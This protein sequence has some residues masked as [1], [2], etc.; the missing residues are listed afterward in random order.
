MSESLRRIASPF[1]VG[2]PGG[3]RVRTRLAV[4]DEEARVLW[5]VGK[6]LGALAGRDLAAR[7]A[8]GNEGD[9]RAERKQALTADATSRWAGALTRTSNDQWRRARLNQQD[10]QAGLPQ[11]IAAIE[12]RLAVAVGGR[13]RAIRGY[14]SP[15]ERFEK[16]RR[17]QV[18]RGWLA[19]VAARVEAGQVSV[20]RD[21][22][23]GKGREPPRL[24][25]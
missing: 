23:R 16:Q 5:A 12:R 18:L 14:A 15:A 13:R 21:V 24:S 22:I 4:S 20:T 3:A 7:C 6:H 8:R 11:A 10:R 1:L 19:K 17:L 9:G 2:L 25:V